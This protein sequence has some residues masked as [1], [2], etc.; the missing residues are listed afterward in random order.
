MKRYWAVA[1]P[2]ETHTERTLDSHYEGPFYDL[3]SARDAREELRQSFYHMD[4]ESGW[5]CY[6]VEQPIAWRPSA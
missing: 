2:Q 6:V 1:R 4:V 3:A 5:A